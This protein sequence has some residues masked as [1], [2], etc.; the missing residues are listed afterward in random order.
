MKKTIILMAL[1][2]S[3]GCAKKVEKPFLTLGQYGEQVTKI[4]AVMSKLQ[5][6]KDIKVMNFMADGVE[7]T[8]AIPCDAIADECNAYYEYLNKIVFLTKDGDLTEDDKKIIESYHKKAV[9]E[10]A[11]SE[12]IIREQW[13]NYINQQEKEASK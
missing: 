11:R 9:K 2:L 10:L 5:A 3:I 13:K 12:Q 7:T 8:R 1:V 6:E 4:R